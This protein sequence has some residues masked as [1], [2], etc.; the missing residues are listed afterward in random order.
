MTGDRLPGVE[1]APIDDRSR[2]VMLCAFRLCD[3]QSPDT[4]TLSPHDQNLLVRE[5]L[6]AGHREQL[7]LLAGLVNGDDDP[8]RPGREFTSR[9]HRFLVL[10]RTYENEPEV[11]TTV[12]VRAGGRSDPRIPHPEQVQT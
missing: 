8:Y 7:D 12:A 9:G 1:A 4:R 11:L 5:H 3:W 6:L 2:A 10:R